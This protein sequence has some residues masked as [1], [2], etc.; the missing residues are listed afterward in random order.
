MLPEFLRRRLRL[1]ALERMAGR[2]PD[3]VIGQDYLRRWWVIPRNPL[4][5]IY[6]HDIRKS[7]DDRALH[8]HPWINCS[9][10][11]AGGYWEHTIA[12]GGIARRV[13]R[14]RGAVKLRLGRAAHRLE[15]DPGYP[16]QVLTL[17]ITGPRWRQWGFHCPQAGWVHW[18]DFTDPD[19]PSQAGRGC[20]ERD[21][22]EP[23]LPRLVADLPP[24]RAE[25]CGD[26]LAHLARRIVGGRGLADAGRLDREIARDR[27]RQIEVLIDEFAGGLHRDSATIEGVR[28]RYNGDSTETGGMT[29]QATLA[30]AGD[31]N[32][33]AA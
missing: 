8:D 1:W 3:V 28:A 26:V 11:L 12:A 7:D 2:A 17:F 15:I 21:L 24:G 4:F 13:W 23:V 20:G 5:N 10:V 27:E 14:G 9:I 19:D 18:Q 6:L 22:P 31:R 30:Q 16:D 29:P 25:E 32:R 33:D